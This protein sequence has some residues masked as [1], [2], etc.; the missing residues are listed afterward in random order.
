MISFLVTL[1]W[2]IREVFSNRHHDPEERRNHETLGEYLAT[3][4]RRWREKRKG[5]R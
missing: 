1:G 2:A 4:W 3:K 5:T